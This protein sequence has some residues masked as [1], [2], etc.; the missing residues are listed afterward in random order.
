MCFLE[1][2]LWKRLKS[3]RKFHDWVIFLMRYY[4][5]SVKW[6]DLKLLARYRTWPAPQKVSLCL[7]QWIFYHT[8]KNYSDFWHHRV[9][10]AY[11]WVLYKWD[12]ICTFFGVRFHLLHVES[13]LC[14]YNYQFG[15]FYY[16]LVSHPIDMSILLHVEWVVSICCYLA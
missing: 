8:G 7:C 10:D 16:C 6:T 15:P 3:I 2:G 5:L 12:D 9:S 13:H 1:T 4:L 11:S 14:C